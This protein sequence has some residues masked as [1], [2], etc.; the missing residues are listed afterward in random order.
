MVQGAD[1]ARSKLMELLGQG[2]PLEPL[3]RLQA[4]LP[5]LSSGVGPAPAP[6]ADQPWTVAVAGLQLLTSIGQ[7]AAVPSA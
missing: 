7:V 6:P 4:T 3:D 2:R 1:E 5:P